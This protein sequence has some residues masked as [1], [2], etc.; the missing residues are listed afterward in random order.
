MQKYE[1]NL[2]GQDDGGL[3]AEISVS[4]DGTSRLLALAGVAQEPGTEPVAEQACELAAWVSEGR[5]NVACA[6]QFKRGKSTL[7]NAQVGRAPANPAA[8]IHLLSRPIEQEYE[9]EES[10]DIGY[11]GIKTAVMHTRK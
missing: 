7:L 1:S 8:R 9:Q 10:E 2:T 11:V 5:F 4:M 3:P 6:S